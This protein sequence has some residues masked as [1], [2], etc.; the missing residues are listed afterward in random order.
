MFDPSELCGMFV[1]IMIA[2]WLVQVW[3]SRVRPISSRPIVQFGSDG[4]STLRRA[5]G[6]YHIKSTDRHFDMLSSAV[7]S[8][9]QQ[10]LFDCHFCHI[11]AHQ[12]RELAW[13]NLSWW[14]R[15]NCKVDVVLAGEFREALLL[16]GV[17]S[18]ARNPAR[19]CTEPSALFI[20][21][22][23]QSCLDRSRIHQLGSLPILR[24]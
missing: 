9:R 17:R 14:E 2:D 13:E 20:A 8:Y 10:I 18:S 19:F 16:S 6:N 11:Q 1:G 7:R 24:S 4:L 23:K 5:F 3:D 21:G 15:L 22:V 12:D